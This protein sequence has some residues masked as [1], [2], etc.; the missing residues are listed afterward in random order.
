MI[1][2][3][4]V[5][6]DTVE[7]TAR[8]Q[9]VYRKRLDNGL[10]FLRDIVE[11]EEVASDLPILGEW[12]SAKALLNRFKAKAAVFLKAPAVLGKAW[13]EQLPANSA[14]PWTME[15][16]DYAQAHVRTRTCLTQVPDCFS[17]SG[18]SPLL[19]ATGVVNVVEHRV[20]CSE[21]NMSS[22]PRAHLI[23]DVQRP[24]PDEEDT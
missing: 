3:T 2:S 13:I 19:L 8:F 5:F 17:F 10:L 18:P 23:V 1:T 14:T 7:V 9:L 21:I 24:E 16:D 15:E 4:G 6:L 22:H 20:L 11:D 12:K